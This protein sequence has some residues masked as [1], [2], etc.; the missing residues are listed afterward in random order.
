MN[1]YSPARPK[2]LKYAIWY[3]TYTLLYRLNSLKKARLSLTA[4]IHFYSLNIALS[5]PKLGQSSRPLPCSVIQSICDWVF[6]VYHDLL[7]LLYNGQSNPTA[8]L[9]NFNHHLTALL[10]FGNVS[11][12]FVTQII[13]RLFQK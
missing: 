7:S 10:F 6:M 4:I 11:L 9:C 12:L 5:C 8:L 3:L 13:T 1:L 2:P